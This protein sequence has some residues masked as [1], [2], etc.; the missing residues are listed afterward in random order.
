MTSNEIIIKVKAMAESIKGRYRVSGRGVP[1][2]VV[3]M[4]K[5]KYSVCYFATNNLW[6]IFYP[7]G[8]YGIEQTKI[9]IKGSE[10]V[11]GFFNMLN[12]NKNGGDANDKAVDVNSKIDE[13]TK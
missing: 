11:I 12:E 7:W 3:T 8:T 4:G 9:T 1:H 2:I 13:I 5:I 10:K 6:R